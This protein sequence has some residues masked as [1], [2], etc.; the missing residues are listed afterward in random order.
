M[1]KTMR[2]LTTV[3][4]VALLVIANV[5]GVVFAAE[6]NIKEVRYN[7]DV[8]TG[9][10]LWNIVDGN[11]ETTY[12][13][14]DNPDMS[15]GKQ[16][17]KIVWKSA[18]SIDTVALYAQ[19]CGAEGKDGQA[20]TKWTIQVSKDNETFVDVVTV[21]HTWEA[22]DDVQ[23]KSVQFDLQKDIIALRIV[24]HEANLSWGH[25]VIG[26]IEYS[27]SS[28]EEE[29]TEPAPTEPAPTEPAPSGKV[30]GYV[31]ANGVTQY[32]KAVSEVRYNDGVMTGNGLW[33]IVDGN[34]ESTYVSE[35]GPDMADGKQF[36]TLIW[37]GPISIDTV[38]LYAQYC[39]AE[40]KDGQAPTKWTIQVSKDGTAFEDV[41]TV[42][43]TWEANDDV[44]S[45]S[46]QFAQ[47][48][49]VVAL[50]IVIHEANLSWNHYVIGEVEVGNASDEETSEPTETPSEIP[51]ET[52]TED[53]TVKPEDENAKTGDPISMVVALLAVSALGITVI[54]KK[55]F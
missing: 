35:D 33:N 7:D 25:Y 16:F 24:I 34:Y 44:Q 10:G 3:F 53:P 11:H 13:S 46:I 54:S 18:I 38:T 27:N 45:K 8:M 17:V 30:E 28:G 52:P 12:V 42:E 40:G 19:Y 9:N 48:E 55:K 31:D 21:E 32:A 1:K 41:V 49:G 50:R 43:H 47:Q 29:P 51:T 15:D 22:N 36:V 20:P 4:L 39:G 37:G 23:S 2:R 5:S 26:E 14:E 6:D